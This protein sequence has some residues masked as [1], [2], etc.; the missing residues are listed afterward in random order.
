[1]SVTASSILCSGC[2]YQQLDTYLPRRIVYQLAGGERIEAWFAKGWCYR[3]A[4]WSDIEC[5]D[6]ATLANELRS[7]ER[8]RD[9][10]RRQLEGLRRSWLKRLKHRF[11]Q[12][13]L[14]QVL[15]ELEQRRGT[16]ESLLNIADQRQ[17]P[18]RCLN[19]GSDRTAT[20]TLD[21]STGLA[22]DFRH[23]C[24]G[25]LRSLHGLGP[26]LRFSYRT[27]TQILDEKGELLVTE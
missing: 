6:S 25:V 11:G 18:P 1:M 19:C 13:Q 17:S 8:E 21:E 27:V 22:Q 10:L 5:L 20:V 3:C 23:Q 2:D 15:V 14:Q 26:E 4:G 24:G 7:V 12:K 16:L 9:E